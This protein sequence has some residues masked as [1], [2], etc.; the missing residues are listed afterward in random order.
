MKKNNV[1][2]LK[3]PDRYVDDPLTEVIR[4][5][6][7]ILLA[8]AMEVEIEIVV[9]G[10]KALRLVDGRQQ[11]TTNGDLPEGTIQ[12]DIGGMSVNAPRIRNSADK[13]SNSLI[14][15]RSS[16]LPPYLRKSK[17]LEEL[18]P[19]LYLKG[20]S[21]GDFSDVL[22]ALVGK[23]ALGLSPTIISRLKADWENEMKECKQ[24]DLSDKRYVY[25]WVDGLH[26]NV[27]MGE[28]QCLLVII[29]ATEEGDRELITIEDGYR[30]SEQFW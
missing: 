27:R 10:Y 26:C 3:T 6:A 28:K 14:E 20:I 7:R 17:S 16:I 1:V 9:E 8:E 22:S 25:G 29:G 19:W 12:T 23:N 5:G 13:E 24:R 2:E 4:K 18:I 11:I 21:T 30:E 15:S